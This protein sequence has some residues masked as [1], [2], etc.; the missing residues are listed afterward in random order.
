M[1]RGAF[2]SGCFSFALGLSTVALPLLALA[3]GYSSVMIGVL[4]ATSAVAQLLVR[5]VIGALMRRY[6]DWVLILLAALL[7]AQPET[8][9]AG[10]KHL[11]HV[12]H[13]HLG[14]ALGGSCQEQDGEAFPCRQ[15]VPV[16][17]LADLF[18]KTRTQ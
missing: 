16:E 1:R 11:A 6:P 10:G 8:L 5:L 14:P 18:R 12:Q 3:E 13:R 9:P 15:V 4:T 7:L 2:P 17:Q